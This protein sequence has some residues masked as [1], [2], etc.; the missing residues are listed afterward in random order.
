MALLGAVHCL[1]LAIQMAKFGAAFIDSYCTRKRQTQRLSLSRKT[2]TDLF[3][4]PRDDTTFQ[5]QLAKV[6]VTRDKFVPLSLAGR[7]IQMKSDLAI[8]ILYLSDPYGSKKMQDAY[9]KYIESQ[10]EYN[11][12]TIDAISIPLSPN[13]SP[14]IRLLSRAYS[15]VPLS[16][17]NM[18][19]LNS[20][21]V[22]R[23]GGLFDNLPFATWS[24]DPDL[25]ER[26]AA[27]NVVDERYTMGK[28]VAYQRFMGKDWRGRLSSQ[29]ND[30]LGDTEDKQFTDENLMSSLS[31]RILE[32]EVE[33]ARTEVAGFEQ[34]L[35]VKTTAILNNVTHSNDDIEEKLDEARL[36]L[37]VA[38]SSLDDLIGKSKDSTVRSTLSTIVTNLNGQMKEAPYRGAIGYPPK[39]ASPDD[40]SKS[41]TSPYSLLLEIINEQLHS[42]VIACVLEEASLFEG[43]LVLGGAIVLQR[44][45]KSKST[46]IAGE[47][48]L[49]IDSEDDIGNIDVLPGTLFVVECYLDEAVGLA[50]ETGMPIY[51]ETRIWNRAGGCPVEIN[52]REASNIR[53]ITVA[54]CLPILKPTDEFRTVAIEGESVASETDAN[55]VRIPIPTSTNI[56]DKLN[57][58][59]PS[60]KENKPVFSTYSPISSLQEY[61]SLTNDD[62]A[63]TLLKLESFQG[64]LPRPRV[65]R[66]SPS[67]ID[68]LML[69]LI[70]ESVRRQY[71]IREAERSND[72]ETVNALKSEMSPRQSLLEQA[73]VAWENGREKEAE[74]LENEADMLKATKADY[75]Q[76]EGAYSTFLDRDDWYERETQARIAR[77]KKSRGID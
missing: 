44:R 18:L 23:G 5:E 16:K 30:L 14:S 10:D 53:N 11:Q 3:L 22:N 37:Q 71:R 41:Y 50:T 55:S 64:I 74:I 47:R 62:K 32:V 43:N 61:D 39:T 34:Q 76:D 35:A 21:L 57:Q 12:C 2:T 75:T 52:L 38:E 48:V 17:S 6:F 63:R 8:D 70:D 36:R 60:R 4:S 15:K 51:L 33:D 40:K 46:I 77:Y 66:E 29:L 69:P 56:F 73:R 19:V 65:V 28:R 1:M 67:A 20:V 7:S 24:I 26:D 54:D 72:Y 31:K 27:N 25:N 45:G 42:D 49:Y 13:D 59:L 9:N 68:N 58:M